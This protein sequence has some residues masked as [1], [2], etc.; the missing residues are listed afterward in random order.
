MWPGYTRTGTN[1]RLLGALAVLAF[2]AAV[3]L[4]GVQH[5]LPHSYY[6]DEVHFVQRA[7][8]FGSGD[9][10]PHWFHKPALYMYLLFL[11]YGVYYCAGLLLGFLGIGIRV[12]RFVHSGCR[13]LH[14][15]WSTN[16]GSL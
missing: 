1:K 6:P 5:D 11:E 16:H 13:N 10:N 12:C 3:R 7:V 15:D 4:W 9:L 14:S 2:G 8:A